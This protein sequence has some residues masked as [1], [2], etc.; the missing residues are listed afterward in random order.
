MGKW[1]LREK[2]AY[3]Y[4]ENLSRGMLSMSSLKEQVKGKVIPFLFNDFEEM[5]QLEG[6]LKKQLG[7]EV[8]LLEK[9]NCKLPTIKRV[10]NEESIKVLILEEA[11]NINYSMLKKLADEKEVAIII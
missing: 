5:E 9:R 10:L 7:E 6:K 3:N 8:L 2:I 1:S 11:D 4:S